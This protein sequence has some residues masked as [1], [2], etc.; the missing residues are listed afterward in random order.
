MRSVLSAALFAALSTSALAEV[1]LHDAFERAVARNPDAQGLKAR[2]EEARARGFA[3]RYGEEHGANADG[4]T[5]SS[6]EVA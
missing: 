6:W 3:A 5:S 2:I 1:T 4:L